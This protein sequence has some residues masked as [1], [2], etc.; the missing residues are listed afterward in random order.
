[1]ETNLDE[2]RM[3]IVRRRCGF[4]YDFIVQT[5]GTR[6]GF[7]LVWKPEVNVIIRSFSSNHI[8]ALIEVDG[9]E[10]E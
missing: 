7:C 4:S 2:K 10:G 9:E 8:D 6:G 1:M 3:E 5:D